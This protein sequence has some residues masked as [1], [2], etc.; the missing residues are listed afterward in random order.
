M[1]MHRRVRADQGATMDSLLHRLSLRAGAIS[2]VFAV[3]SGCSAENSLK[4]AGEAGD[5]AGDTGGVG[6]GVD[7]SADAPQPAW[8]APRAVVGVVEGVP[9]LRQLSLQIVDVDLQTV[10][11]QIA[12]PAE[13]GLAASSPDLAAALWLDVTI[14]PQDGDCAVPPATL[15]LGIG[16]IPGDVR[17]Q[18]GPSGL[19]DVADSIYGAFSRSPNDATTEVAAFGYA[20]TPE[21]LAGDGAATLPPPDGEYVLNPLFLS[22]LLDGG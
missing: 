14:A 13:S 20:G 15:G 10:I 4:S 1:G 12:V 7:D 17:A 3:A 11:C 22:R 6:V 2:V 18:L 16:E 9:V 19:S 5:F 21:D 8:F